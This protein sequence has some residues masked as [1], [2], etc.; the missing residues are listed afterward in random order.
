MLTLQDIEAKQTE[1]A[2]LIAKFKA[3][4]HPP[5]TLILERV[6]IELAAGE[7]YAGLVLDADG[8]SHHLILLPGDA[9]DVTWQQAKDWAAKAGGEL[10]TRQEQA[11]LFANLKSQFQPQWYWSAEPHEVGSSAW[12]QNFLY[13][14]QDFYRQ[15]SELRAR[16]VRRFAA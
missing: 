14:F 12:F 8:P 6:E 16:A 15:T 4:Q 2:T 9:A 10:P 11:L 1:L 5:E 7:H 13:G 3:A